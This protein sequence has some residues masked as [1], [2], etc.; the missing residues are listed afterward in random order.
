MTQGTARWKH[1]QLLRV[2]RIRG[3]T[4]NPFDQDNLR[5]T[6]QTDGQKRPT[7]STIHVHPVTVPDVVTV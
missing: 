6:I 7:D 1:L 5:R 3:I 4:L 2:M